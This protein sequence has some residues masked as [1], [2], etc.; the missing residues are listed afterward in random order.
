MF[1]HLLEKQISLEVKYE[2]A[3]KD[4]ILAAAPILA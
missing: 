2:E 4:L 1:S 3:L